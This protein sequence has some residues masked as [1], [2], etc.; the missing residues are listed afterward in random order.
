MAREIAAWTSDL[1]PL[2]ALQRWT[3]ELSPSDLLAPVE[4]V[5]NDIRTLRLHL[6][7][8]PR[9]VPAA[10]VDDGLPCARGRRLV[11]DAR[12]WRDWSRR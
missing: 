4:E 12:R 3:P 7:N 5:G 10:L 9:C 8:C 1:I 6:H 2:L 11:A